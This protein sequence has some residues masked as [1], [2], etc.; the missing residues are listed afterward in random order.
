MNPPSRHRDVPNL[1]F[2]R[3]ARHI[4]ASLLL[5]LSFFPGAAAMAIEEPDYVVLKTSGDVE[6]RKYDSYIVAEVTVS[7]DS[8]DNRAFRMLAGYIFGDNATGEKMA[9]TAPVETRGNEHAFVMERK[10]TLDTLPEPVDERVQLRERPARIVAVR[11]FSGRWSARN[12]AEQRR[13]LLEELAEL[14]VETNG[15]P[16]LARYNSPFTPWFLR[17]NEIIVPVDASSIGIE[18][19]V[20]GETP[21]RL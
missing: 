2:T 4:A 15:E 20:A 8:A 5:A 17:R 10:Y 18:P 6:F 3:F 19:A 11:Q 9:M 14:G 21:A 16:E 12:F 13:A 7:G 1:L